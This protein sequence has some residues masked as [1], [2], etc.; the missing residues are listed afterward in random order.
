MGPFRGY[1]TRAEALCFDVETAAADPRQRLTLAPEQDLASIGIRPNQVVVYELRR[2]DRRHPDRP[3]CYESAAFLARRP[4]LRAADPQ[5]GVQCLMR[6][7][8]GLASEAGALAGWRRIAPERRD[9]WQF[10]SGLALR[11]NR[12]PPATCVGGVSVF[13]GRV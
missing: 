2:D 11:E 4:R 7:R 9:E 12:T 1:A 8:G 5:P 13:R 3:G 10:E 6:P